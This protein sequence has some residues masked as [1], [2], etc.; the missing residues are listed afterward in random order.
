MRKV[1]TNLWCRPSLHQPLSQTQRACGKTRNPMS[2]WIPNSDACLSCL[3]KTIK[4]ASSLH[5]DQSY[6]SG[7]PRW[8]RIRQGRKRVR[9][10]QGLLYKVFRRTV[11]LENDVD[12]VSKAAPMLNS[13]KVDGPVAAKPTSAALDDTEMKKV[14]EE[15]KWL[16][17]EVGKLQEENRQLKDD[18]LRL[19]K[20]QRPDHIAS[21][22]SSLMGRDVSTSSLPSL[23]VVIAAIFIGFFLGKFIL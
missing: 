14:F 5:I 7:E 12:A 2:S 9:S 6:R 11:F 20:A 19:R 4:W 10:E 16:Q 1:N 13:S 21:N 8:V 15:C 23:L 3:L 18:G 22:S 17:T